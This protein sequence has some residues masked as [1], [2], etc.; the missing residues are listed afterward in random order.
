M[1]DLPL[2]R[3]EL[4]WLKR[5]DAQVCECGH[6]FGDHRNMGLPA[7]C[8]RCACQKQRRPQAQR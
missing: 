1:T 4:R 7:P 8:I 3:N 5:Y 2:T 6:R